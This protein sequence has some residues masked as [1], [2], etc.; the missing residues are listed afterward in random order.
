VRVTRTIATVCFWDG[1]ARA[2][3]RR[4]RASNGHHHR[5]GCADGQCFASPVTYGYYDTR[6]RRWPWKAWHR[7]A[8]GKPARCRRH[9]RERLT[10]FCS[11]AAG[12]GR[13]QG[14]ATE[15]A[16]RRAGTSW[17]DG[18]GSAN[19]WATPGGPTTPQATRR[20]RERLEGNREARQDIR[21]PGCPRATTAPGDAAGR[22]GNAANHAA[23]V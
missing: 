23:V 19:A 16:Y 11:A 7:P 15:R 12:A 13:S 17:C 4:H 2:R 8:T 20:K 22:A 21:L 5:L 9:C 10:P 3:W 6:W 18:R 1:C 14:A